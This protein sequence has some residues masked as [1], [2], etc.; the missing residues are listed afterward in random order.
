[1]VALTFLLLSEQGLQAVDDFSMGYLMS[2]L[3][4]RK[5]VVILFDP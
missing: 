5:T 4:S 2:D 3:L 1:M